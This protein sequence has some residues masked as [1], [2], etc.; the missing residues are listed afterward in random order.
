LDSI[1]LGKGKGT[2][3][4]FLCKRYGKFSQALPAFTVFSL[5]YMRDK[6]HWQDILSNQSIIKEL[7]KCKMK[8]SCLGTFSASM[9]PH[10]IL[11]ELLPI[12][13]QDALFED[14]VKEHVDHMEQLNLLK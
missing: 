6:L 3:E 12:T 10:L 14:L 2:A 1:T 5:G 7:V 4:Q 13:E 11:G 8:Q 9:G